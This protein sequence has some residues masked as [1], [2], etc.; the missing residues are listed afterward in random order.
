MH[1][2]GSSSLDHWFIIYGRVSPYVFTGVIG[3]NTELLK[4]KGGSYGAIHFP[5]QC[6]SI[7]ECLE[8]KLCSFSSP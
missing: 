2:L 1:D 4:A 6:Q 7:S 8:G 3:K 5:D